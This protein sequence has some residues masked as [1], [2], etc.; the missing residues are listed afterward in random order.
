MPWVLELLQ[1]GSRF[2]VFTYIM[3]PVFQL[4]ENPLK[5]SKSNTLTS[6]KYHN[7]ACRV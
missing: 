5:F 4:V 7:T 2:I 1:F 6:E 3:L